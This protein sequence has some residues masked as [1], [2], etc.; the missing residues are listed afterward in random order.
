M[1]LEL[2]ES[3]TLAHP[4]IKGFE[5]V[6]Y[7]ISDD[8]I[9]LVAQG[10]TT[11]AIAKRKAEDIEGIEGARPVYSTTFYVGLGIEAKQPGSTGPRRLDISWP[12]ADFTKMVKGWDKFDEVK[13]GIIVRHIKSSGLPDNVFDPGERQ[14]KPVTKKRPKQ[15]KPAEKANDVSPDLPVTK[16]PRPSYNVASDSTP[17]QIVKAS[18]NGVSTVPRAPQTAVVA[19]AAP[20]SVRAVDIKDQANINPPQVPFRESVAVATGASVP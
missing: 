16:K 14:P 10:D 4:F 3:L 2:T 11:P 18:E 13:M 15:P 20:T 12:T 7:C 9:R 1:K 17:T 5:Q 6:A 8:E 19:T